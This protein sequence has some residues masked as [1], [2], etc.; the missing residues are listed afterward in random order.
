MRHFHAVVNRI[1][2]VLFA[3]SLV[4]GSPM[5][6]HVTVDVAARTLFMTGGAVSPRAREALS[7][8]GDRWIRKPFL[9][10][11]LET[12]VRQIELDDDARPRS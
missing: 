6:A 2:D 11:E 12:A 10:S 5:M 8:V 7:K 3:V 1:A 9:I 4:F